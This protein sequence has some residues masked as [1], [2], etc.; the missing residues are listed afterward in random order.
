MKE[1][2][3]DIPNESYS[4]SDLGR[5]RGPRGN[6]LKPRVN[7]NGYHRVCLGAGRD[8][9]IHRLVCLAF[10]GPPPS[11]NHVDHINHDRSDNR[12]ANLRWVTPEENRARRLLRHGELHGNSKLSAE[13]V[14]EIRSLP[15]AKSDELFAARFGVSRETVRDARLRKSWRHVK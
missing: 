2:W 10:Y 6:I 1:R 3:A 5:I 13:R 12:L 15:D 4:A 9:Y 14:R 11:G 7:T 8:R